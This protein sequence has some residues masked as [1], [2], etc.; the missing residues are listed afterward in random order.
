MFE[1]GQDVAVA[2]RVEVSLPFVVVAESPKA[3]QKRVMTFLEAV[4]VM[5]GQSIADSFMLRRP[6]VT[7]TVVEEVLQIH[8]S[9]PEDDVR[10]T[11]EPAK[12]KP[13]RKPAKRSR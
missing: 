4:S 1:K 3:A 11:R 12:R 7:K 5:V 10:V 13:S 2:V 6:K 9:E 8:T